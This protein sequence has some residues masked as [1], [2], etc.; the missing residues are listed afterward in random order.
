MRKEIILVTSFLDTK[1]L[2][3]CKNKY[4]FLSTCCFAKDLQHTFLCDLQ[5]HNTNTYTYIN[6]NTY[7]D[8]KMN[9]TEAFEFEMEENRGN[10]GEESKNVEN[11]SEFIFPGGENT[12]GGPESLLQVSITPHSPLTQ[13]PA[14]L[15]VY[16]YIHTVTHQGF[17]LQQRE[18]VIV[19]PT[20]LYCMYDF[21]TC[22]SCLDQWFFMGTGS[23]PYVIV[24]EF[25]NRFLENV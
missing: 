2:N 8:R 15:Y 19:T 17:D 14:C 1:I 11:I 5:I 6:T 23:D 18:F 9:L 21:F 20:I 3:Q 13:Q 25:C 7:I 24:G 22:S 12:G 4:I 16:R 10:N